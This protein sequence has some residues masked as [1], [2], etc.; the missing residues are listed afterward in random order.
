MCEV[1]G[2]LSG[3]D[4]GGALFKLLWEGLKRSIRSFT[5]YVNIPDCRL[6]TSTPL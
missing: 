2:D 3:G 1:Q 6:K 5:V 4:R